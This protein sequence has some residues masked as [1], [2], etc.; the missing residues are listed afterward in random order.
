MIHK[1]INLFSWLFYRYYVNKDFR[2]YINFNLKK[3]HSNNT[4]YKSKN[5]IL[6]DLFDWGPWVHFW[7]Y[8]VNFLSKKYKSNIKYYYFDLYG[9][10]FTSRNL[11]I[12]SLRKIYHSF[13]AT[14]GILHS[15]LRTNEDYEALIEKKFESLKFNKTK[16]RNFKF[17]GINI[18]T[19]IYDTY[20]RS[21]YLPTVDMHDQDLKNIFKKGFLIFNNLKKYFKENNVKCVIPSHLCY[22][23]YGIIVQMAHKKNIPVVMINSKNNGQNLFH[24]IRVD[25]N[26]NVCENR[27]WEYSSIFNK[28]DKNKKKQFL[29]KGQKILN[30]R[31]SGQFDRNIPYM[32][33]NPFSKNFS[34]IKSNFKKE[35]E[36]IF[37]FSHCYFD[38][39]HRYR[40]MI[41]NDFYEQTKYFLDLSNTMREYD[42]YYKPHPNEIKGKINLHKELLKDYPHVKLLNNNIS[43]HD[44]MIQNPK[45]VITNH[46][47]VAHEF[48]AF[49]IPVINT[50]DN[51]HVNYNFCINAKNIKNLNNIMHN[52]NKYINKIN[53]NKKKLY[54][55]YY[56]HYEHFLKLN[57]REELITDR[58][59]CHPK[60][61]IKKNSLLKDVLNNFLNYYVS[62]E[63]K[64]DKKIQ[65]YLEKFSKHNKLFN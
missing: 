36:K 33:I 52:L 59:F 16:L 21:K 30:K 39:P 14:K 3:W 44:V 49:K 34:K 50:G 45:C 43:H 22:I 61:Q 15:E 53:F 9:R 56:L 40:W 32:K 48:A 58:Y 51:P 10:P 7:S 25:K 38:N 55:F 31:I 12:R 60:L 63:R 8:L 64:N 17:D 26:I 1:I 28:F 42:W 18:G 57:K 65:T 20:L 11:Y 47:T 6:I 27:Y 46:G 62:I 54:E 41:F 5:V 19:L 37:L 4:N 2:N 29:N 24:L 35:K 13:N 23:T